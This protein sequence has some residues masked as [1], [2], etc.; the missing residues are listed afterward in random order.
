VYSKHN[1][2]TE[3]RR[4]D[5]GEVIARLPSLGKKIVYLHLNSDGTFVV[6]NR[7]GGPAQLRRT[8]GG[9]VIATLAGEIKQLVV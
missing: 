6:H 1:P 3:L 4:T 2:Q 8:D 7:S 5:S 9:T